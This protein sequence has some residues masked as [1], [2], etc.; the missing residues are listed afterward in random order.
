M[1]D[2]ANYVADNTV[3]AIENMTSYYS[4]YT[5]DT[6]VKRR[7]P[8]YGRL[9]VTAEEIRQANY[10]HG[11]YIFLNN[12]RI[13]NNALAREIGVSD[14]MI[15]YQWTAEDIKDAL[16][17]SDIAVFLDAMDFGPEGIKNEFEK[18]AV[19]LEITDGARKEVL[20]KYFNTDIDAKIR[21]KHAV[22]ETNEDETPA[23]KPKQRRTA[24]KTTASGTKQRRTTA[25]PKKEEAGTTVAT[26]EVAE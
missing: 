18:L 10:E 12:L 2:N 23:E 14:D 6:G 16:T 11:N 22:E 15:E 7:I 4:G 5:L 20:N 21:N 26:D 8:G 25:E 9:N 1:S 13:T 17:T 24:T 19:E 3:V